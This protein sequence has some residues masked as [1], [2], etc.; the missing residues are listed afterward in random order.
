MAERKT[1]AGELAAL[2]AQ[3]A[4]LTNELQKLAGGRVVGNVDALTARESRRLA[5]EA[6]LAA[7]EPELRSARAAVTAEAR[8][9]ELA[10]LDALRAAAWDRAAVA[11]KRLVN[12]LPTIA[13]AA[14][15]LTAAA[16]AV[17][18]G[19]GYLRPDARIGG[20]MAQAV[21]EV[22]A[23]L[24]ASA[25]GRELLGLPAE[26]TEQ[27]LRVAECRAS[28][29][30]LEGLRADMQRRAAELV[31][32]RDGDAARRGALERVEE[33]AVALAREKAKLAQMLGGVVGDV[34]RLAENIR[35]S[36]T[37]ESV[38]SGRSLEEV[39]AIRQESERRGARRLGVP[40][41][42]AGAGDLLIVG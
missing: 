30:R 3:H 16:N 35:L 33:L 34:A 31:N 22:R 29:A 36:M 39:E 12:L 28:I 11:E 15:E 6:A 18:A 17:R 8:A 1:A 13:A 27:E 37:G 23:V 7:L 40:E 25:T 32:V 42:D 26:P 41:R 38:Y 5:V 9:A 10:E 4:A 20:V 19:G 24:A 14:G 2:E 21:R